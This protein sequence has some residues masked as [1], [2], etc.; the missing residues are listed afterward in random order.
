MRTRTRDSRRHKRSHPHARAHPR[1]HTTH[2]LPR[3]V[4]DVASPSGRQTASGLPLH[5]SVKVSDTS[6]RAPGC[7][8]KRTATETGR[9]VLIYCPTPYPAQPNTIG[10]LEYT[11]R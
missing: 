6:A 5:T 11:I 1:K 7:A 4:T 8:S 2:Q 10:G 3:G 9:S